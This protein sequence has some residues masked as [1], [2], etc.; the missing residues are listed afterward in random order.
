M[1]EIPVGALSASFVRNLVKNGMR[2]KFI[3][4]YTPYLDDSKIPV[5]YESIMEGL[6]LPPNKSKEAPQKPLKYRYPM[7]KGVSEFPIKKG[8]RRT[9]RRNKTTRRI[10]KHKTY[11]RNRRN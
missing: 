3:E 10:R 7:I 2:D 9:R 8:G 5:L 4:L 1:S 11:R 6:T